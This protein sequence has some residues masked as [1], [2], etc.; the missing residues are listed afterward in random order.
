MISIHV[1]SRLKKKNHNF[2]KYPESPETIIIYG[3]SWI[4]STSQ[5]LANFDRSSCILSGD[6]VEKFGGEASSK[7]SLLALLNQLDHT[8]FQFGESTKSGKCFIS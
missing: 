6:S 2:Q 8:V 5:S 3:N 4:L 7:Y 1:N